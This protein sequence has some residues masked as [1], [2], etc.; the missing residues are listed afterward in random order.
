MNLLIL[1]FIVSLLIIYLITNVIFIRGI[2]KAFIPTTS[3]I[4]N[5]KVSIVIAAKNEERK[6]ENLINALENQDYPKEMF[7]II[8]VDDNSRDST[9]ATVKSLIS[10]KSHF[11]VLSNNN[12]DLPPK[13]GALSLGI[14]QTQNDFILITDADCTPLPGWIKSFVGKFRDGH[15]F[16]I[17]AA[18]FHQQNSSDINSFVCF[19]NLRT[20]LLTF[21]AAALG[22]PYSGSARSFGFKKEA[23]NKIGGY[24]N[25][26]QTIGGDDD[27]LLQE[28]VKNNMSVGTVTNREAFVYSTTPFTFI[29]Y[30]EQ[31]KRHTKTSHHYLLKN[32]IIVGYWHLLNS[33][34]FFSILLFPLSIYF[35]ILFILK[36]I[37]DLSTIR[38]RQ[39][40]L[41]YS[42]TG[43][44]ILLLQ[45]LY[46]L[47]IIFHF[48]NSYTKLKK[49][50]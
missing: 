20:T 45:F 32:K 28:A 48:F 1:V 26:L 44:E 3:D 8:I 41:A 50:K 30:A 36:M 33:F 11:T 10:D 24:K 34:A 47:L 9:F 14:E 6:I 12:P 2:K 13:K 49:W 31:K 7:E 16:L 42:F 23:F 17:G 4:I 43:Y 5:L 18:P 39:S 35:P 29:E 27:L 40:E 37:V 25:T 22:I 46:E 21:S 38:R 19:E 15:D